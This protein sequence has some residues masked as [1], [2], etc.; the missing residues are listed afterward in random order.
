[1]QL[2]EQYH[3][4]R[5]FRYCPRCGSEKISIS[6]VKSKKCADCGLDWYF[7]M[8]AAVAGLIFN[9]KGKLLMSVRAHEPAKGMLDLPGGFVD[10]G[11]TAEDALKREIL[12]ELNLEIEIESY[13]GT[14]PN[15]YL[16]SGVIY[17]TLD[18]AFK[19]RALNPGDI[20]AGDDVSG[21]E[22]VD[23]EHLDLEQIGLSSIKQMLLALT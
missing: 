5:V 12:E 7:N 6:S 16:F 3:P 17:H 14:F 10:L 11:E 2:S 23:P 8:S 18:L 9:D 1:M 20:K 22:F 13:I 21:F 19:C 15:T 4:T